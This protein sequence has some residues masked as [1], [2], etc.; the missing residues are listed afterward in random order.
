[1]LESPW[2]SSKLRENSGKNW[3]WNSSPRP[4]GLAGRSTQKDLSPAVAPKAH[5]KLCFWSAAL[6]L[7]WC[8]VITSTIGACVGSVATVGACKQALATQ[9]SNLFQDHARPGVVCLHESWIHWVM[10][11]VIREMGIMVEESTIWGIH[12]RRVKVESSNDEKLISKATTIVSLTH[13]SNHMVWNGN[14]KNSNG[15]MV[16]SQKIAA[17]PFCLSL[18]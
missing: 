13:D 8:R 14:K 4:P 1:M 11:M 2:Q 12:H 3:H 6:V 10:K 9:Q 18:S 7:L 15:H 16:L 5:C 17:V